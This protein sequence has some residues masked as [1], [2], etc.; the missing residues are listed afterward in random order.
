MSAALFFPFSL[1]FP[2][3]NDSILDKVEED[4]FS[5]LPLERE[6]RGLSTNGSFFLGRTDLA[7][8]FINSFAGGILRKNK[9]EKGGESQTKHQTSEPEKRDRNKRGKTLFEDVA[10][11]LACCNSSVSEVQEKRKEY[12]PLPFPG[13]IFAQKKSCTKGGRKGEG[14]QFK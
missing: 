12:F 5:F 11:L 14:N 1:L 6:I 4:F 7:P 13:G 9:I 3:G 8:I 10:L 2:P